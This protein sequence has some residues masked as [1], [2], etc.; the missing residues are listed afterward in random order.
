MTD[1]KELLRQ[2]ILEG[3]NL[4]GQATHGD[5]LKEWILSK[6][7]VDASHWGVTPCNAKYPQGRFRF[8]LEF[9]LITQEMKR[10]GLIVSPQRGFYSLPDKE[11]PSESVS[12][13]VEALNAPVFT[14]V[15]EYLSTMSSLSFEQLVGEVLKVSLSAYNLELSPAT[16]DKGIDGYL[17]FDTLGLRTAVFQ[18][19]RYNTSKVTRPE[20]DSFATSARQSESSYAIFVT[21]SS[22][23]KEARDSAQRESIRLVDGDEFIQLMAKTGVGLRP[24]EVHVVYEIDPNWGLAQ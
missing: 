16:R 11:S 23:T 4:S 1:L 6:H 7:G 24:S 15:R 19:K 14:E 18:A 22:F 17:H 13:L 3:L 9:T 20:L 5:D 21:L 12:G 2:D 8:V 10:Q